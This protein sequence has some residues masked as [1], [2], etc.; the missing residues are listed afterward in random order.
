[1]ANPVVVTANDQGQ[2]V[3]PSSNPEFGYIRVEQV[4]TS[5]NAGWMR[6]EKRSAIIRGKFEDLESL[7]FKAGQPLPGKIQVIESLTPTNPNDLMQDVKRTK[8]DGEI[9]VVNDQ[10]I[11]RTA[12]YVQDVNAADVLL[13]HTN[14]QGRTDVTTTTVTSQEKVGP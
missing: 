14:I 8:M 12:V 9:L 7:N 6:R 11:Y 3:I 5:F 10:P 4:T 13:Q 2:V 1:M